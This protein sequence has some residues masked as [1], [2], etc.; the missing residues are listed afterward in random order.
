MDLLASQDHCC[1]SDS[2]NKVEQKVLDAIDLDEMIQ[3][4][5]E[6]I[7]IPSTTGNEKQAQENI[8]KKLASIEMNVDKWD[9]DLTELSLHP[10]YSTEVERTDAVD[11]VGV[12]GDDVNGKSLILN[13]HIDVVPVGEESNWINPPWK[14]TITDGKIMGRGSVDMK[15]GFACGIYA[16]KAIH[17]A[18]IKLKGQVIIESVIGEEDGGIGALAA[19]LRG[20][21]ADGAVIMEPTM[22]K[23]APAQ[24]GALC[25]RIEINGLSAHACVREEG[26]SAL[27]KFIPIHDAL[28]KLEKRRN[29]C[30]DNPL[31]AE[32][33]LPIPLNIGKVQCG[34]WPSSV[35]ESLVVEGRYGVGVDENIEVAKQEFID[36]LNQVVNADQWLREHKPE[37]EWWGGQFKPALVSVTDPI[38]KT[39]KESYKEIVGEEPILEG[40]TYGSDMRHLVNVG[41]IPTVLFGPGDVRDCH[42]PNEAVLIKDL[43]TTVKILAL[44]ILR[45]CEY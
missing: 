25:F 14:G 10:D 26:I 18:G 40:V 32:Y 28:I 42:R 36:T 45:F 27:E 6:L 23:I 2:M 4:I 16:L 5:C 39:V 43:E 17:D 21:T 12:Y 38:V 19:T 37:M 41:K 11:V 33:K 22:L 13:G 3:Y 9:V 30:I 35:P 44:T 15:G 8:A 20:Y 7:S 34:N 1:E 24:A 29:Q 31:Y